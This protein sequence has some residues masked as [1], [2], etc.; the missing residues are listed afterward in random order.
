M[1][2][3]LGMCMLAM[4]AALALGCGSTGSLEGNVT[5]KDKPVTGGLI[6]CV[7]SDG[8]SFPG[9][10]NADGSYRC[11]N[12]PPGE[13]VVTIKT[14]AIKAT[15]FDQSSKEM[16]EKMG[17]DSSSAKSGDQ[18][19]MAKLKLKMKDK[20]KDVTAKE[21]LHVSIP[22]KYADAKTSGLTVTITSGPQ[23]QDFTLSD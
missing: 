15:D 13:Y 17:L 21:S 19:D 9:S 16:M 7:A 14:F 11:P 18:L 6:A 20:F 22:A 5:Y 8:K 12:L 4:I 2:R 10:L 1:Q 23:K 3:P